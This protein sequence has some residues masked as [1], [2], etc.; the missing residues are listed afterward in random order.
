MSDPHHFAD[1]P[2][3]R[4]GRLLYVVS[5]FLALVGGSV[6]CV[7]ALFMT[8]SVAGR[9]VIGWPIPGDYEL[10]AV[11]SGVAVFAMLPYCELM[12]GNVLVDFFMS[13]ASARARAACDVL[14]SLLFLAIGALATWRLVLGGIDMYRNSDITALVGFPLWVTVPFEVICMVVLV[15]VITYSLARNIAALRAAGARTNRA[16]TG[17]R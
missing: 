11:L 5:R 4:F 16:G 6:V 1:V 13:R 3:D 12:R 14:G 2:N 8:T 15:L 7:M 10:T 17:A 9:A